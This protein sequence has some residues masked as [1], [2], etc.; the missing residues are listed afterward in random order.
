M[1]VQHGLGGVFPQQFVVGGGVVPYF[2]GNQEAEVEHRPNRC[3]GE[4]LN[5]AL[6]LLKKQVEE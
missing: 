6:L 4:K 3:C 2:S 5:A 1:G